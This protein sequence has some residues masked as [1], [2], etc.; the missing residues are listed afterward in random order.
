MVYVECPKRFGIF[1]KHSWVF[2]ENAIHRTSSGYGSDNTPNDPTIEGK[3]ECS[4]CGK[5]KWGETQDNVDE[6]MVTLRHIKRG[7]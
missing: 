7:Y 5:R 6:L 2:I 1:T 3:Y 4:V